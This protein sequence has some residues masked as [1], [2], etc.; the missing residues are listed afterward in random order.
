MLIDIDDIEREEQLYKFKSHADK[1]NK[2]INEDVRMEIDVQMGAL[3]MGESVHFATTARWHLH[4]II[5]WAL[6]QTGPADIYLAM[7]SIKEYQARVLGK[8]KAD[9]LI[10]EMHVL[11]DYRLEVRDAKVMPFLKE[12]CDS[13]GMMRTHAKLVVLRNEN[14]G[15]T[16]TGSANLT[17]NTRADVGVIT[18]NKEVADYRIDWI[19]QNI[20]DGTGTK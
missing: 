15:V 4:D 5:V 10:K 16:I 6:R 17:Q 18:C 1:C 20:K 19:T 7:F 8:M 13:I 2:F 11:V 14:W 3:T 12:S 9:K